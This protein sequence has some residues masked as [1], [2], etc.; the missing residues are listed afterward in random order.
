MEQFK[1]I[2][3]IRGK[4]YLS[5]LLLFVFSAC[6]GDKGVNPYQSAID[7][8]NAASGFNAKL[9]DD[10]G[11]VNSAKRTQYYPPDYP[12]VD[13]WF[14]AEISGQ[15]VILGGLPGQSAFYSI[16]KTYNQSG[17]YRNLYW[18]MLQ[19]KPHPVF[20]YRNF[21]GVYETNYTM[22]VA[23]SK[24]LANPQWGEGN[25]WQLYIADYHNGLNKFAEITLD[26][27]AVR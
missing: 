20:G 3:N 24:C 22:H 12:G 23:L 17:G 9:V 13:D 27:V 25:Q 21:L 18:E 4:L 15:L 26:S 1:T 10:T 16:L 8:F 6:Y 11:V 19:V 14:A 2:K 7:E 5:L